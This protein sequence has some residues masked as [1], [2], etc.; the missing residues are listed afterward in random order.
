MAIMQIDADIVGAGI[1][2]LSAA[3]ALSER[4]MRVR[5]HE[6]RSSG[7][8]ASGGLV[9]A[10]APHMPE[11][12]NAKKAFQLRALL[13]LEAFWS[14]VDVLSG[15]SSGYQ[16]IGRALP[17]RSE[18]ALDQAQVRTQEVPL[19]WKNHAYWDVVSAIEALA[20]TSHG[21]VLETLT[22]KLAP[23]AAMASLANAL[24][25]KGVE[26]VENSP[27]RSVDEMTGKHIII[28]AGH[29]SRE[30]TDLPDDFWF[31]AKGQ[32]AL[33]D[34]YLPDATPAIFEGGTYVVPHGKN[35]VAVGSTVEYEWNDPDTTDEQL[36]DVLDKAAQLVPSLTGAPVIDRWAGIR[37]R[38]RLPDPV[39]GELSNGSWLLA[40][41]FKTGLAFGPSMGE[42]LAALLCGEDP[43]IPPS[44]H[45]AN[46]LSR[47]KSLQQA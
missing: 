28:A 10:L 16:R 41:G 34:I 45:L 12:W 11:K 30:L 39:I 17:L 42:T 13:K 23:R 19:L 33:I 3:W 15:I 36:D 20:P 46:Q 21:Y 22:A 40:G 1:F 8:G 9:G 38:A 14:E 5:V 2:G 7:S 35:G 6:A 44:F 18:R 26:I 32:S 27:V 31:G 47:C 37:P 4:G 29:E 25:L 24:R 43:D